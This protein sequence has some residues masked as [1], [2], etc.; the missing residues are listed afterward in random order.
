[1]GQD[2]RKVGPRLIRM[3]RAKGIWML[4]EHVG[5]RGSSG[6]WSVGFA[7]NVD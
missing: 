5:I 7:A 2:Q 6:G 3:G 4:Q 1:M